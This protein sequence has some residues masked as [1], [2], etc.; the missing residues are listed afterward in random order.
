MENFTFDR[1]TGVLT[2]ASL[3][4][5]LA[6]MAFSAGAKASAPMHW[7]G[8]SV[9][10]RAIRTMLELNDDARFAFPFGD[11]YWSL[12]LDRG[13]AYEREVEV[14][15]RSVA[16]IDF[17]FI[18][19]GANF[20]YW[21]VLVSSGPFG[22][23]PVI[24]IEPSSFNVSRLRRNA[25]INR[26]RIKIVQC[27]VAATTG[28]IVSLQGTKHEA[29]RVAQDADNKSGATEVVET[30][31]LE[32]LLNSVR[33]DQALIV[34]LDIE[35]MEIEAIKGGQRILDRKTAVIVE[36]HGADRSHMISRYLMEEAG[37]QL[38]VFDK[39]ARGY[40]AFTDVSSL[41][42]IKK[43]AKFGYNVIAT[44]SAFWRDRITSLCVH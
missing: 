4:E 43:S 35:G 6:A 14:F 32:A 3:G 33:P 9:G 2:G 15:L 28:N 13:F 24:A 20:G 30:V 21:S 38:F 39:A 10:C 36:D 25:Q 8:F 31:A 44:R 41:D 1:R 37:C 16:D 40:T 22:S 23:H 29:L 26:N 18:D 12:L 5:R 19:G 27:A 17:C 11:G 42:R 7:R 34:K